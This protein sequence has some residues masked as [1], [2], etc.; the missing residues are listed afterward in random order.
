MQTRFD[1]YFAS[2]KNKKIPVVGSSDSHSV[3]EGITAFD[4]IY[5]IAFV[6]D[7]NVLKS[8]M[9]GKTVAVYSPNGESPR[10]CG[11]FEYSKYAHFLL[12]CYFPK[13]NALCRKSG[14]L[15]KKYVQGDRSVLEK[16]REAERDIRVFIGNFFGNDVLNF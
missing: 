15:L 6:S 3:W 11:D 16:I 14:E 8:I 1:Q 12:R 2:L 7:K 5:T 9:D 10:T 4:E 13:H